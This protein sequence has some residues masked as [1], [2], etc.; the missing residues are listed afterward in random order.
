MQRDDRALYAD[1]LL[2]IFGVATVTGLSA[3]VEGE[4]SHG[5]VTRF[6]SGQDFISKDL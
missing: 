2:S 3:M 6:L 4:V 5:R 1:Y